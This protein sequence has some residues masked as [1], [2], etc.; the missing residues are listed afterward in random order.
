METH[1]EAAWG[2]GKKLGV[3]LLEMKS[4]LDNCIDLCVAYASQWVN[5]ETDPLQKL[6]HTLA[7]PLKMLGALIAAAGP[8]EASAELPTSPTEPIP[9][10]VAA[11]L[12]EFDLRDTKAAVE[13]QGRVVGEKRRQL[14]LNTFA[15][16]V[17]AAAG[18]D[19]RAAGSL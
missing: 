7:A 14:I 16:P 18:R 5:T 17:A 10:C 12:A 19:R 3:S 4:V 8:N 6:H 9:S 15:E 11:A 1:H 2:A 13:A